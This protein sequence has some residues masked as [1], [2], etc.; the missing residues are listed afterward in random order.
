MRFKKLLALII[1]STF[2]LCCTDGYGYLQRS[3]C[4]DK[5]MRGYGKV[6]RR[7]ENREDKR[8]CRHGKAVVSLSRHKIRL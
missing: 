6:P 2:L 8:Y 4:A 3:L 5:G 1:I 7:T